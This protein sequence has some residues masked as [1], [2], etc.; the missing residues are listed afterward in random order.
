M[1]SKKNKTIEQ[2]QFVIT[3][4]FVDTIFRGGSYA[5]SLGYTDH[6]G[7]IKDQQYPQG[8]KGRYVEY[9]Q[10]KDE[11]GRDRA[12]RY[13]FDQSLGRLLTR[14]SDTDIYGKSQYAFLK[15]H[16]ECEGSP[17]GNYEKDDAG[18]D[19][20]TGITFRELNAAADAAI[21]L[22]AD[23]QRIKAEVNALAL[24]DQTLEEIAA[25]GPNYFGEVDDM[26]RLKVVEFAR[27]FP[28]QFTDIFNEAD[29]GIRA[30]IR[31]AV[32]EGIFS[33]QQ[34]GVIKW[35]TTTIGS[36]EDDAVVTLRKDKDMVKALQD[37]LGLNVTKS[38]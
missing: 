19:V 26:M 38:K 16:P 18:K 15:N 34:S 17:N 25:L 30:I 1:S 2:N 10:N 21:A 9:V 35:E 29:R 28:G 24:D 27:R 14:P 5:I 4:P 36:S 6:A 13:R 32:K 37:K 33:E 12:K 31:K 11:K 8:Q 20:Q 23:T 3:G 7:V 22:K